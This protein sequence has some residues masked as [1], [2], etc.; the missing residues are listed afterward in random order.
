MMGGVRTVFVLISLLG[1]SFVVALWIRS[2]MTTD[3]LTWHGNAGPGGGALA[4]GTSAHGGLYLVAEWDDSGWGGKR[5]RRLS[6]VSEPPTAYPVGQI[7]MP[8]RG[9][10]GFHILFPTSAR[11]SASGMRRTASV[12]V[13]HAALAIP[14]AMPALLRASRA[15]KRLRGVRRGRCAMCGYD[16]RGS[17]D[18]CPECGQA[19]A[20]GEAAA[21]RAGRRAALMTLGGPAATGAVLAVCLFFTSLGYPQPPTNLTVTVVRPSTI[22]LEWQHAPQRDT[23]CIV[24]SAPFRSRAWTPVARVLQGVQSHTIEAFEADREFRVRA[25]NDWGRSQASNVVRGRIGWRPNAPRAGRAQPSHSGGL[26]VSWTTSGIAGDLIDIERSLG[27]GPFLPLAALPDNLE[28]PYRDDHDVTPGVHYRYRLR[29]A[30]ASDFSDWVE[31]SP[32]ATPET[33]GGAEAADAGPA[34]AR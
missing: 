9:G 12:I 3:L 26:R 21:R 4:R 20:D 7:G 22:R 24:E 30:R 2:H 5:E 15:W 10:L 8:F 16:L 34:A 11:R 23:D 32:V 6:H 14:L 27:N 29:I 1:S 18:R 19:A 33:P 28:P 17:P 25:V 31:T 13:P